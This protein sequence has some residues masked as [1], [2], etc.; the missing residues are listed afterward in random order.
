M[1]TILICDITNLDY[2][3][4]L[5]VLSKYHY[6]K[7]ALFHNDI[8]KKLM[9]GCELLL[10]KYLETEVGNIDRLN[11]SLDEKKPFIEKCEYKF[12][13]SHSNNYSCCAVSKH[14]VGVDIEMLR[15]LSCRFKK[16]YNLHSYSKEQ[17][18]EKWN[19]FESYYKLVNNNISF[20][21]FLN[22]DHGFI[23]TYKYKNYYLSIALDEEDIIEIKEINCEKI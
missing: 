1:T 9:A 7:I 3:K 17:V 15:D 10:I 2:K 4:H 21:E 13:F 22:I 23:R 14:N 20:S 18:L 6:D 19:Q 12:S 11:I 8:D 5:H 16:R